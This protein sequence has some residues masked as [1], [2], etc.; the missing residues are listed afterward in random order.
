MEALTTLLDWWNVA[1]GAIDSI[2]MTIA[3]VLLACIM[4]AVGG[5]GGWRTRLYGAVVG[6]M[7]MNAVIKAMGGSFSAALAATIAVAALA[8]AVGTAPFLVQLLRRV[9]R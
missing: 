7:I 8:F 6:A 1:T 2:A 5:I 3:L 9:R 4:A